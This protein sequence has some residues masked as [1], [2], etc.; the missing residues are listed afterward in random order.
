[1]FSI[2]RSQTTLNNAS[3]AKNLTKILLDIFQEKSREA[4][5]L[6]VKNRNTK[7]FLTKP[8]KGESL[9][10]LND[11]DNQFEKLK[12]SHNT[13]YIF[14]SVIDQFRFATNKIAYI[15]SFNQPVFDNQ[16][17]LVHNYIIL[18]LDDL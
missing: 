9:N 12:Y 4:S 11:F 13:K 15:D 5:G 7:E 10:T 14:L 3:K 8:L 1:M 6:Y 17:S 18:N 2:F 16:I